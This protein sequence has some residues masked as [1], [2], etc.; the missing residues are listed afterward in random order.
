MQGLSCG[1]LMTQA[2][3][4]L[5]GLSFRHTRITGL[6]HCTNRD[7]RRDTS[8]RRCTDVTPTASQVQLVCFVFFFCTLYRVGVGGRGHG[9][10]GGGGAPL[11]VSQPVLASPSLQSHLEGNLCLWVKTE[12]NRR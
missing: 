4:R 10:G 6:T 1:G 8:L 3:L 7:R 5:A 12:K 9:E 2:R 11:A